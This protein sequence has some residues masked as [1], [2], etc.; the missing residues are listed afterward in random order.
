[1]RA[2]TRESV[3]T[4]TLSRAMLQEAAHWGMVAQTVRCQWVE[5]TTPSAM[6]ADPESP[7]CREESQLLPDDWLKVKPVPANGNLSPGIYYPTTGSKRLVDDRHPVPSPTDT[8][9]YCVAFV[10]LFAS[11]CPPFVLCRDY[12]E[13]FM[14]IRKPIRYVR[15]SILPILP[16]MKVM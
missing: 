4:E 6:H 8:I 5:R 12:Y 14:L 15:S 10:R 1:M 7:T 9:P 13:R 2:G 16:L 3:V 11:K